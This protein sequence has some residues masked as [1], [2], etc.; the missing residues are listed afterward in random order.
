VAPIVHRCTHEQCQHPDIFKRGE[1]CSYDQCR[2]GR[3]RA[4]PGDSEVIPTFDGFGMEIT[5]ITPPGT[6]WNGA[7]TCD[8]DNCQSLYAELVAS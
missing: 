4:M 6:P 5:D 8:C 2:A 1:V 7:V 3:H